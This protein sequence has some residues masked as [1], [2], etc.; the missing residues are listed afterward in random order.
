S[1][2]ARTVICAMFACITKPSNLAIPV[3][4]GFVAFTII[5]AAVLTTIGATISGPCARV[6]DA[7]IVASNK[8]GSAVPTILPTGFIRYRP[9]RFLGIS[10]SEHLEAS[11]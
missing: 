3:G 9:S 7:L 11:W 1:P 2:L 5:G 8:A 4:L 10:E 6:G